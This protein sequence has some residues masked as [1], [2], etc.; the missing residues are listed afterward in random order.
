[1]NEEDK[2]NNNNNNIERTIK[3]ILIIL[4]Q[5]NSANSNLKRPICKSRKTYTTVLEIFSAGVLKKIS[6]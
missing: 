6:P 4:S 2:D 3:T 1:M 5:Y